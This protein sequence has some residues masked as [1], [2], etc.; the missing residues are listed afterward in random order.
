[1]SRFSYNYRKTFSW[2]RTPRASSVSNWSRWTPCRPAARWTGG[3]GR[4]PSE[5]PCIMTS[6][7]LP[8]AATDLSAYC[9]D[10]ARRA[11]AA[12]R[13][14]ATAPGARKDRWLEQSAA[15]LLER[16]PEILAA[17]EQD[18]AGAHEQGLT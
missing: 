17:N 13:A 4:H 10:L 14:L 1:M 18:L 8:A 2:P 7:V 15:A 6:D 16:A 12:S 11:R 9:L 3:A 5:N